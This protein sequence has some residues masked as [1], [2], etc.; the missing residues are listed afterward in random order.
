VTE[1]APAGSCSVP[2]HRDGT[3]TIHIVLHRQADWCASV[4]TLKMMP[5]EAEALAHALTAAVKIAQEMIDHGR[6]PR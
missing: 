4:T 1:I 3:V 6:D 5:G 2:V